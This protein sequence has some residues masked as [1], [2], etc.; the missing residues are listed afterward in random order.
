M[1]SRETCGFELHLG[2]ELE[3]DTGRD[4]REIEEAEY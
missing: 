2:S 4:C 1:L 3:E